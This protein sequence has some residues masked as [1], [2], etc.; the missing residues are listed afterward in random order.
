MIPV[1]RPLISQSDID[2]VVG[3]L[4]STFISGESPPVARMEEEL[5]R[6]VGVKHAIALSSGTSAID[7]LISQLKIGAGDTCVLPTFTIISTVSQLLRIGAKVKL[8]DADPLTWSIDAIKAAEAIDSNTRLVLPV[9]IY[10]LPADME[11]ILEKSNKFGVKVIEDSAEA[12]GVEYNGKPC[13]SLGHASVFSFY[14]NKIVTGGEGGAITTND[15][16]LAA[17]L[18]KY[19]SL[20]HDE[21]RFVHSDL[22]W[23][24]RISGLSAS[25]IASQLSRIN[26]LKSRKA[27][28]GALYNNG[29]ADHPWI[30][31]P[32]EETGY[33]RNL[34]WVFPILL[35][36]HSEYNAKSLQLKLKNLGIETRRFFCPMHLQPLS[37]KYKFD[38]FSNTDFPIAN[39]LW[40]NGLYLPSGLGNT[41]DEILNVIEKLWSL[42]K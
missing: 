21:E 2:A 23:N 19:R 36:N 39:N 8:I 7:L 12:L 26:L 28:I 37:P 1:N 41:D 6:A 40:E 20:A 17:D 22:G 29:L 24:Y 42:V 10:G 31:L 5:A 25:L 18:R 30:V 38:Q 27:E 15:T 13:G 34:Y 32:P 9:H 14:A 3:D 35:N 11:P 4:N 16:D 33:A